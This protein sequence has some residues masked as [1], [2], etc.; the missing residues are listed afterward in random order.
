MSGASGGRGP[1]AG[2]RAPTLPAIPTTTTT[3]TTSSH[4]GSSHPGLGQDEGARDLSLAFKR[5][6]LLAVVENGLL[7]KLQGN[8][9]QGTHFAK[10]GSD[11]YLFLPPRADPAGIE[12]FSEETC[13]LYADRYKEE[14]AEEGAARSPR[15]AADG[16]GGEGLGPMLL[17]PP[18]LPCHVFQLAASAYFLMLRDQENQ[19]VLFT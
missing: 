16:P 8:F 19:S 17:P 13:E 7:A 6:S 15:R 9:T 1:R 5:N 3:T 12:A 18:S 4:L 2:P 11:A 14:W 10:I